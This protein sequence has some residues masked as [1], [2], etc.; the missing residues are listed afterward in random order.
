VKEYPV[1]IVKRGLFLVFL[2]INSFLAFKVLVRNLL[3]T[4]RAGFKQ[5]IPSILKWVGFGINR[6][7]Y[8]NLISLS[9]MVKHVL[10][11]DE[12]RVQFSKGERYA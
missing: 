7:F 8:H 9:L 12:L 2:E 11:K 1:T 5:G 6:V 3:E 4:Q 10:G